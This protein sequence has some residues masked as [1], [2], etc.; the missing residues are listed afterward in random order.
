[1]Q[2]SPQPILPAE[3]TGLLRAAGDGDRDA[4]DRLF[5]LVYAELRA[6][7]DRQLRGEAVGHTLQATALVHE[8]YL[9]LAVP[10]GAAA[11][12]DRA[13]FFGIASRAMRQVLV[14]HARRRRADKRGGAWSRTTLSGKPLALD[15][16]PEELL[17]LDAA[18]EGLEP[19]QRE[20]VEMRFFGGMTEEE[21]AAVLGVS[22]R[23]V[24]REWVKARAWLYDAL[25][26]DAG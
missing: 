6:M 2:P 18:L 26:P 15:A 4:F 20:I 19:R 22:D 21:V 3:V 10:D 1:M 13:H 16:D 5:P 9:K 17:A 11:W 24:R 14:D 8:A 12:S 23:T 25:Y 7:A